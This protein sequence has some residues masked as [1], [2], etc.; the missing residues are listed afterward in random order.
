ML[1]SDVQGEE[2]SRF[3]VVTNYTLDG[4]PV[5]V[6]VVPVANVHGHAKEIKYQL[7]IYDA[8]HVQTTEDIHEVLDRLI[9]WSS[10]KEEGK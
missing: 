9:G 7:D 8:G 6:Q 5:E 2:V 3:D 10:W 1:V 4:E